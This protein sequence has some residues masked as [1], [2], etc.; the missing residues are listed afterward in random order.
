M[1][2]AI[3]FFFSSAI[4]GLAI[5]ELF[6]IILKSPLRNLLGLTIGLVINTLTIF[7]VSLFFGLNL[8]T[9]ITVPTITFF[10]S[11]FLLIKRSATP[12]I[13]EDINVKKNW[14]IILDFSILLLLI[15]A[16][17][18]KS[19]SVETKG[20]VAGNRLV[21]TDWP[22]HIAIISSF[23]HGN[24]F[25]PQNPLY[26]GQLI[27][28]PFFSDFLSAILQSL[29]ASLK[30]SL[31]FPGI[32]LGMTTLGLIYFLGIL[33]T[34]KKQIALIG[35]FVG[36]FWGGFGFWYFIND[37]ITS[38]NFLETLKF[39]PHEYT[40]YQDKGLWFFSFLYSELLPQRAFLFGLPLFFAALIL[41][42]LGIS[43]SKKAYLFL[44]SCLVAVMPFFH[45]HS[46]ISFLILASIFIALTLFS[47]FKE[48]KIKEA[49]KMIKD[50]ILYYALPIVS[51]ALIQ[52]PI[53]LSVNLSQTLG[54][55]WGW[56]KGEENFFIFWF[57]N[58]GFFWPLL[59]FA[60]F[61]TKISSTGKNL[62]I[63]SAFLFFLSNIFR[64]APWPYD[65]LK[66]MTY[67]YLISAFLVAASLNYLFQ[68][69]R[70]GKIISTLLFLSLTLSAV[71][72]VSR[73][74]DT[75]KTKIQLWSESDIELANLLVEKTP[76]NS[77]ILTAA[78]HDHPS[79]A[80]AGRKTIIGFP[81]NAWAWG[82]SDWSQREN[83]VRTIFRADSI[84]T[85]YLF[86]K[87]QVDYVLISPRERSFESQVNDE[88]FSKNYTLVAQGENYKL[89]QIK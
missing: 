18:A 54:L 67:W 16:I 78:I 50:I 72:E 66:I 11:A 14:L 83:D 1:V 80:L 33:V 71:I 52:L 57:K 68:K 27:S 49:K 86:Q 53:F 89:F 88:Y 6:H 45:M 17:F 42:I 13:L 9:S 5:L 81:G 37:L 79:T 41:L 63:A 46:Y 19:I 15:V 36:I 69:G 26:S 32:I 70:L 7:L 23:V 39:P 38:Q 3:L 76:P 8:I 65:N 47:V 21:W 43:N 58:T 85:S 44:S 12:N 35:V 51:L 62:L 31:T 56:M 40:F 82:L 74:M 10:P 34:G 30:V 61:K 84:F 60:L 64:F 28:Y 73:I 4:F 48:K 77:L 59:I 2:S 22:I 20:I 87:Y 29:G 75:E 25:P 55:N 24:N